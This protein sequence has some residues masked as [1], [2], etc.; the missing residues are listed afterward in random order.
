MPAVLLRFEISINNTFIYVNKPFIS[1]IILVTM[2]QQPEGRTS[3]PS[4][5][6][7]LDDPL[8]LRQTQNKTRL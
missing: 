5:P 1:S 7:R 6:F 8:L 2:K 3:T 4:I